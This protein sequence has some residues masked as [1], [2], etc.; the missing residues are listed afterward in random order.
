MPSSSPRFRSEEYSVYEISRE[1]FYPNL[2]RFVW[3]RQA[4]AHLDGP[5]TWRTETNKNICYRVWVQKREI[6]PRGTHKH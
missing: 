1:M 5:Q 4:G 6:I 3:R 2:W